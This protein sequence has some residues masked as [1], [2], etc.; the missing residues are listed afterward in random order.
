MTWCSGKQKTGACCILVNN[1]EP[2]DKISFWIF[3]D[4]RWLRLSSPAVWSSW[5]AKISLWCSDAD[6]YR[7]GPTYIFILWAPS[8][9]FSFPLWSW[10]Q[11]FWCPRQGDLAGRIRCAEQSIVGHNYTSELPPSWLWGFED[12]SVLRQSIAEFLRIMFF[13]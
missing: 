12:P 13:L 11:T 1:Y 6:H 10:P 7:R 9:V 4:V 2:K 3:I 5:F 8:C